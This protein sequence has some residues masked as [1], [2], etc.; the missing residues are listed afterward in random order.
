M[1][2]RG[3]V[4]RQLA[5]ERA[6]LPLVQSSPDGSGRVTV[7]IRS[8]AESVAPEGFPWQVR[9]LVGAR[10]GHDPSMPNRGGSIWCRTDRAAR[11]QRISPSD[12]PLIDCGTRAGALGGCRSPARLATGPA[13][14]TSDDFAWSTR[15]CGDGRAPTGGSCSN[16]WL[17]RAR[18][19]RGRHRTGTDMTARWRSGRF[20]RGAQA[21]G[22]V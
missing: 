5:F 19:D 9:V 8:G 16:A 2:V 6:E 14:P 13:A 7:N 20:P 18:R 4:P 22:V 11:A 15:G 21:F 3:R 12:G 1:S 10:D 17:G